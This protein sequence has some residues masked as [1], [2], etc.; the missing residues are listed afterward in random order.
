M[1]FPSVFV[2]SLFISCQ[3]VFFC[4]N[5]PLLFEKNAKKKVGGPLKFHIYL[6]ILCFFNLDG[7][8]FKVPFFSYQGG[9]GLAKLPCHFS[10]RWLKKKEVGILNYILFKK[11]FSAKSSNC[12]P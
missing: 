2:T 10:N 6:S 8:F 1:V 4:K 3:L 11:I 9:G 7:L 5:A 12:P